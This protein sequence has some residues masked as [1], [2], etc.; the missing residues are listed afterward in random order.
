MNMA[1]YT[2]WW[3][4]SLLFIALQSQVCRCYTL[5]NWRWDSSSGDD[6]TS[7]EPSPTGEGDWV[8]LGR[9]SWTD[10]EPMLPKDKRVSS[11]FMF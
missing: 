1:S 4:I 9:F 5:M 8:Q 7:I 6:E 10:K 11:L 3:Q 2:G